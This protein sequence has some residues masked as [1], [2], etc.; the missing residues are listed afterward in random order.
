VTGKLRERIADER[1]S[2]RLEVL[3][4]AGHE[5]AVLEDDSTRGRVVEKVQVA[6]EVGVLDGRMRQRKMQCR[7]DAQGALVHAAN[8]HL[9]LGRARD[10]GDFHGGPDAA[11][12]HELHVDH[13]GEAAACDTK[14]IAQAHQ[15]LVRH[16]RQRRFPRDPGQLIQRMARRRLFDQFET[17]PARGVDE[18]Q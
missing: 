2:T 12:L 9:D 5:H 18:T 15:A 17:G 13:V 8:H 1:C 7:G 4:D 14:G 3:H 16:D 11:A 10:A 6:V